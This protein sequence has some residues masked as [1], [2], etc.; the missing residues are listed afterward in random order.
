[1]KSYFSFFNEYTIY[2]CW[3]DTVLLEICHVQLMKD[4][5]K[6][7]LFEMFDFLS[8]NFDVGNVKQWNISAI[9]ISNSVFTSK[10][11][12]VFP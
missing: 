4:S 5:R 2:N 12:Y 8:V 9:K 7:Y 3:L 11:P 10:F 6:L 1:M